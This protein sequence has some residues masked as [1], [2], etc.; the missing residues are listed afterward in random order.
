MYDRVK[1]D[2]QNRPRGSLGLSPISLFKPFSKEKHMTIMMMAKGRAAAMEAVCN[3][4]SPPAN[5]NTA[6][7]AD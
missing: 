2:H 1:K 3:T 4:F 5:S 6:A 7:N